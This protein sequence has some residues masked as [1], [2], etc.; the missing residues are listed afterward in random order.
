MKLEKVKKLV[1]YVHDKTENVIHIRKLKW[2]LNHGPVFKKVLRVIK[3]NQ[4]LWLKSY[5]DMNRDLR[6]KAKN[7][8]KKN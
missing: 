6:K 8:L 7:D 2:A 1:A 3:F 4:N 5:I